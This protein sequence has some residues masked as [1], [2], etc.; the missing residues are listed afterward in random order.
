MGETVL[1]TCTGHAQQSI[2]AMCDEAFEAVDPSTGNIIID[3]QPI[4]GVKA[5]DLTVAPQKGDLVTMRGV[6]YKVVEARTDGQAGIK[7]LLHAI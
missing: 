1:Y 7:I 5:I 3:Q 4:I 2:Q 6:N